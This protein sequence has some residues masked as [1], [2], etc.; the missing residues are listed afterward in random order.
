[1][2][3]LIL[4]SL[5]LFAGMAGAQSRTQNICRGKDTCSIRE[6]AWFEARTH[7]ARGFGTSCDEATEDAEASFRDT[8]GCEN[9]GPNGSCIR[10]C[11][12]YH[13]PTNLGLGC[14]PVGQGFSAWVKCEPPRHAPRT[15]SGRGR[16]VQ[17]GPR[18]VTCR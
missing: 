18:Q 15:R 8:H 6:R 14:L 11:G 3:A 9:F 7:Y 1:M 10:S 5:V 16:C 13:G 2:K 12:M 17:I 4:L